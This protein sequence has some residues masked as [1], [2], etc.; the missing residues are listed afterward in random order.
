LSIV[1]F[2]MVTTTLTAQ[3]GGMN[4]GSLQANESLQ[5]GTTSESVVV[6]SDL[7]SLPPLTDSEILLIVDPAEGSIV[8]GTGSDVL[9]VFDGW[10]WKRVDGQNDSYLI[11]NVLCTGTFNDID[12][13]IFS[14]IQIGTQC[15]MD[16][17]LKVTK[18][19]DGTDI[20]FVHGDLDWAALGDNN[21]DDA[22]CFC[23]YDPSS[24]Y[25]F[26]YTYAAAIADNW[27]H[28]N[29]SDQGIC[30]DGWHLPTNAE[31]TVLTDFLGG[32]TVAGGKMK[33]TGTSH[34]DSPNTDATNESGFTALP[35]GWRDYNAGAISNARKYGYWW[36]ATEGSTFT[37]W[38]YYLIFSNA[39]V[40]NFYY[41]KS[42]GYS[43][44]CL[45]NN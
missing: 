7:V 12:G 36:S 31:W 20:Q 40:Y 21:T 3:N 35:G 15:W 39:S 6:L 5:V 10:N 38:N 11:V 22:Y 25:G 24:D 18:F 37:A 29:A 27:Q 14:G 42:C 17:N 2:A 43:V 9:L 30:P 23:E 44:R 13:N 45:R 26:L 16:R 8:Y 32:L 41:S 19:P 28:D 4:I 34:W 33:E 1:V